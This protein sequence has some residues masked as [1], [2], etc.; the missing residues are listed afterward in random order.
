MRICFESRASGRGQVLIMVTLALLVLCGM[1][2]LVVDLGWSYFV[3]K[4]AQAAADA[5]AIAA[6]Q[7]AYASAS[8]LESYNC[9]G[10]VVECLADPIPCNPSLPGN[11]SS[12]CLY[13]RLNGFSSDNPRQRVLVQASDQNNPPTVTGCTPEVHHPPTADPPCIDVYYWVTVRVSERIPQLFSAIYGNTEGLI[14]ARATAAVAQVEAVGNLIL[15]N[16]QNDPWIP[17]PGVN[18]TG[19]NLFITGGGIIRSPSVVLSSNANGPSFTK[20]PWAGYIKG[21]GMV[22]TPVTHIRDVGGPNQGYHLNSGSALWTGVVDN[23]AAD[24]ED[25]FRERGGNPPV[26]STSNLWPVPNG[27]LSAANMPLACPGGVC[28]SG[29]YFA[30]GPGT[31][32]NG[33]GI[34]TLAT[35][36]P[37]TIAQDISFNGGQFGEFRFFGGLKITG[38]GNVTTVTFGPG[39]YV[40]AGTKS[41][42]VP[43]IDNSTKTWL[44]GGSYANP[45]AD[46]GRIF[47]LTDSS[48]GGQLNDRVSQIA[49]SYPLDPVGW[50]GGK[51]GFAPSDLKSG[52]A[53]GD[54]YVELV[55]LSKV[56]EGDLDAYGLKQYTPVVIWQD[57]ANSYVKYTDGLVDTSCGSLDQPCYNSYPAPPSLAP[58]L[59]IWATESAKLAGAIY[60]PRGAWT[61]LQG[62]G[63]Y[64]GPLQIISGAIASVGTS[65]VTLV[66]PTN[67]IVRYVTAL[68][69]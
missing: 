69:E 43:L 44:Q 49:A 17:Q 50:L 30:I 6:V 40:L 67:P 45:D 61:I 47:I 36:N 25:P 10:G 12:A 1:L 26:G 53:G 52:K 14:S 68:V 13:A 54:S 4:S 64:Q 5:A 22:D 31:C 16:R 11:L 57:Q 9:G 34:C 55:G 38:T 21:T 7:A 65:D 33:T 51:L 63:K 3:E 42:S 19:M 62:S 59:S 60:Q 39:R 20:D 46:L 32:P 28:Q 66:G 29:N 58:Q 15:I 37:I 23:A 56:H 2:G 18:T 35:G 48:Y 41:E 8:N 27:V 24:Y